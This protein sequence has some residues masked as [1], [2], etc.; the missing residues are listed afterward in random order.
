MSVLRE[1]SG[2]R[3]LSLAAAAVVISVVTLALWLA[4]AFGGSPQHTA[5]ADGGDFQLDFA[6]AE[7]TTYF[8][9]GPSEGNEVG[10]AEGQD[11][12]YDDRTKNV[13]VVEQL[14]AEDFECGDR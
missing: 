3:W 5:E 1:G 11:L 9:S 14:E 4:G 10:T 13:D 7:D 6:A 2:T 8:Q 12:G